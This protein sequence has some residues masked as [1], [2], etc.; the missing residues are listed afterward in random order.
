MNED[1]LPS[2]LLAIA[3]G[4]AG[5]GA[6]VGIGSVLSGCAAEADDS[7]LEEPQEVEFWTPIEAGPYRMAGQDPDTVGCEE[8][9]VC[10]DPDEPG[11]VDALSEFVFPRD[12]A[13]A[14]CLNRGQPCFN[15]NTGR[16]GTCCGQLQCLAG[17]P[18]TVVHYCCGCIENGQCLAL[19]QCP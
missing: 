15:P 12:L 6:L 11:F 4:L 3:V 17:V 1:R 2:V 8:I 19:S 5:I 18:G 16:G 7:S 14:A 10:D 9:G 13:K